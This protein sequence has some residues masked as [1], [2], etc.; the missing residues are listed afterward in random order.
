MDFSGLLIKMLIFV[1]LM[2]TGY[3][4]ARKGLAGPEFTKTASNL[5]IN[6][7]MSATI[8]NS[9][10]RI[11]PDMVEMNFGIIFLVLTISMVT[12]FVL[13]AIAGR[14]IPVVKNGGGLF[15]LLMAA[16][17]SMFIALPV[18]DQL[19][20]PVAVFYCSLSAIHFNVIIYTYG[21]WLL[22]RGTGENKV[23]LKDVLTVPLIFTII[24]AVIFFV[25]PPIPRVISELCGSI[26][27]ATMPMSMI[28]IGTS[29]GRVN[30]L[31]TFKNGKLYFVSFF[32]L[33]FIPA[34]VWFLCSFVTTDPVL[35]TSAV[36]LAA[37][38]T[39]I[40]ISILSIQYNGSGEFASEGILHSTV[41]SM[42]I[43]PMWVYILNAVL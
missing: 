42:A 7:F 15:R 35:L 30:L 14:F 9:V 13:A 28:V 43:I 8:I 40:V 18:L 26:S 12:G 34:V 32:K 19:F 4:F 16:P 21:V 36:I 38:P 23:N 11:S 37:S 5:V 39:A 29:L 31:D 2:L 27:G 22:K 41:L 10:L 33:I 17:N 20:G 25:Q 6:I 1:I 24:A 3:I